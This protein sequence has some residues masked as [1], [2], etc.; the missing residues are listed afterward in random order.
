[1][2]TDSGGLQKEAYWLGVPCVTLRD[3]TE[4]V[5]TVEAGWNVLV[6]SDS[7]RSLHAVRSFAPPGPRPRCTATGARQR[8]ASSCWTTLRRDTAA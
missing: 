6:G 8:D 1:M 3:E 7:K 2:L 4:W 5:E